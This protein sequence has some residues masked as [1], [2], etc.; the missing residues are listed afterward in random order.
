MMMDFYFFIFIFFCL[1]CFS[2]FLLFCFSIAQT[3]FT[4]RNSWGQHLFVGSCS[5]S[6]TVGL[7]GRVRGR[8]R[9][10]CWNEICQIC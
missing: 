2:A 3:R 1:C 8:R 10:K 6:C 5:C 4:S 9:R 7:V